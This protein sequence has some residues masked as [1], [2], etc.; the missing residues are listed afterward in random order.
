MC[1]IAEPRLGRRLRSYEILTDKMSRF[2]SSLTHDQRPYVPGEQPRMAELVKL[3]TEPP[4]QAAEVVAGGGK[5]G[6]V[7]VAVAV[8][9]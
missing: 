1:P 6:V 2:W 7:E 8:A 3:N 9:R 5:D 4:D